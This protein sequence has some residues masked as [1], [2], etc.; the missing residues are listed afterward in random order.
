M[1]NI[2]LKVVLFME[3]II[4]KVV[5]WTTPTTPM[6]HQGGKHSFKGST[7]WNIIL[8][9]WSNYKNK[10]NQIF[11]GSHGMC[12]S[13][14]N[15][16]LNLSHSIG[17][18][19]SNIG[20]GEIWEKLD[21]QIERTEPIKVFYHAGTQHMSIMRHSHCLGVAKSTQTHLPTKTHPLKWD[22]NPPNY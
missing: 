22:L 5:L 11:I 2:I 12:S 3:N 6:C 4:L 15:S 1:E 21:G 13:C 17:R 7:L 9:G 20:V 8:M 18:E 19:Y 10:T 16:Y 14:S